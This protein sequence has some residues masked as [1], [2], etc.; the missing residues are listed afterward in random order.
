MDMSARRG[1]LP[2]LGLLLLLLLCGCRVRTADV[3]PGNA[4]REAAG[5]TREAA[6][7][8][9][10]A[11][12]SPALSEGEE[13]GEPGDDG[14][15]TV[16]NPEAARK[17]YDENAPVEILSGTE[18]ALHGEGEGAG[19][20][21]IREESS[22]RGALLSDSAEE[23]ATRTLPAESAEEKG[24]SEDGAEADSA[25]T[26]YT[27][28]LR[29]RVDSLFECKRLSVYWETERDRVT[30]HKTSPEHALIL[31]AGC[32]DVSARL[33]IENLQVDDDWV[34]RKNPG[35][36]VKIPEGDVPVGGEAKALCEGLRRREGWAGTEAV[37]NSRILLLSRG[38]LETPW[39][40]TAAA[41]LLAR[42]AYPDLFADVDPEEM[43]KKLSEEAA[44]GP[45]DGVY[46]YCFGE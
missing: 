3:A 43:L 34:V 30:V 40:R 44:G 14:S 15:R 6:G 21:R 19:G 1:M 23:A 27:V 22:L 9:L 4:P 45:P 18:R 35:V 39:L 16:E 13:S 11:P 26:Y 32:N 8:T 10:S 33:L 28:L 24:V 38:M 31:E 20:S 36:I 37:R 17:E 12:E 5:E 25:L 46:Y 2:A 7:G 29:D 41:V 42:T